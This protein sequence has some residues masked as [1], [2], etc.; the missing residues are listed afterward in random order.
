MYVGLAVFLG[1]RQ[2]L[3]LCFH[4]GTNYVDEYRDDDDRADDDLLQVRRNA[5][6]VTAV[7]DN[8]DHKRTDQGAPNI[9]LTTE[10]RSAADDTGSDCVQVAFQRCQRNCRVQTADVDN[11]CQAAHE[12]GHTIA[13]DLYVVGIDTGQTS[14]FRVTAEGVDLAAQSRTA[15]EDVHYN[16]HNDRYQEG[17]NTPPGTGIVMMSF[18]PMTSIALGKPEIAAEPEI[19]S[20]T[21]RQMFFIPRVAMKG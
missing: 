8:L 19:S 16:K 6:Q 20:A 10:E 13:E 15:Q 4:C 7:T 17:A 2:T 11:A 3:C 1:N 18:A 9:T 12:T 5:E 14:S 21:P